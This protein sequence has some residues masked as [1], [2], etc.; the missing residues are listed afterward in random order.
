MEG[1][2]LYRRS[3]LSPS[4]WLVLIFYGPLAV[5]TAV[6]YAFGVLR[7]MLPVLAVAAAVITVVFSA[8]RRLT[9]SV[10]ASDLAVEYGLGW[11]RK[12]IPRSEIVSAEPFRA[13]LV[14][15]GGHPVHPQGLAVEHL[16][17]PHGPAHP[18]ERQTLPDRHRR[19]R[20]LGRRPPMSLACGVCV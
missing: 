2:A 11:P 5:A 8:G 7:E 18:L 14:V 1:H 10:T 12:Q 16:G 17:L 6:W 3:Q 4:G 15:R 9:V 20:S 19:P 13:P